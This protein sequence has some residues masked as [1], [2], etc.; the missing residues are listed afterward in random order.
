MSRVDDRR[1]SASTLAGVVPPIRLYYEILSLT[2][3]VVF[4]SSSREY[5]LLSTFC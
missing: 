1:H 4:K 5:N 2:V 3:P